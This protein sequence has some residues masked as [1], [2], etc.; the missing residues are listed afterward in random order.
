MSLQQGGSVEE[1]IAAPDIARAQRWSRW[2]HWVGLAAAGTVA[3]LWFVQ[4]DTQPLLL[5]N[6]ARHD[7]ISFTRHASI[8][9]SAATGERT[10]EAGLKLIY[11][12]GLEGSEVLKQEAG[13]VGAWV[14]PRADSLHASVVWIQAARP[15][16]A[17]FTQITVSHTYKY[18]RGADGTWHES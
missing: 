6:G 7:V 9:F 1:A 12:T 4:P 18:V 5:P 2:R 8:T 14:F 15:I 13:E 17:R 16:I 11:Y 10:T 3:T